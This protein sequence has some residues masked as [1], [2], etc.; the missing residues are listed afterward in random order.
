M[1]KKFELDEDEV[2]A[3]YEIISKEWIPREPYQR[4][5]IILRIVNAMRIFLDEQNDMA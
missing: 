2:K 4:Y 1:N 3:I 5:E